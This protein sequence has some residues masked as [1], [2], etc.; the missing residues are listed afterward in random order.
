MWN[1]QGHGPRQRCGIMQTT[2]RGGHGHLR[3]GAAERTQLPR[4]R[5]LRRAVQQPPVAALEFHLCAEDTC[6]LPSGLR[7]AC[8]TARAGVDCKRRP[9]RARREHDSIAAPVRRNTGS[10]SVLLTLVATSTDGCETSEYMRR[11]GG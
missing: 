8:F 3:D 11:S 7:S 10:D 9:A 2:G 5:A 1:R 4:A 6:G